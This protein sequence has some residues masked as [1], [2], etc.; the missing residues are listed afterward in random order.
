MLKKEKTEFRKTLL[1]VRKKKKDYKRDAA[2][3]AGKKKKKSKEGQLHSLLCL[4]T[5]LSESVIFGQETKQNYPI[6]P[7]IWIKTGNKNQLELQ[8]ETLEKS[9]AGSIGITHEM[10]PYL[11]FIEVISIFLYQAENIPLSG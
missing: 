9:Q 6:L 10:A 3:G 5:K 7:W 1:N 2:R 8:K 4:F 11:C